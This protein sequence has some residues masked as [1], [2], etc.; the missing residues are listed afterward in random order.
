[1]HGFPPQTVGKPNG[2]R[3]YIRFATQPQ[4]PNRISQGGLGLFEET[5]ISALQADQEGGVG[6]IVSV[7][8]DTVF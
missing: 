1:M 4:G 6:Q 8:D 7:R 2:L 5:R 3:R